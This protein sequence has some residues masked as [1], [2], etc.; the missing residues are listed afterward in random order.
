M[1]DVG[2][3]NVQIEDADV[4]DQVM[5]VGTPMRA[6][7]GA[8]IVVANAP[9]R[10]QPGEIT[11][12]AAEYAFDALSQRRP[13]RFVVA[14]HDPWSGVTNWTAMPCACVVGVPKARIAGRSSSD[15]SFGIMAFSLVYF[16]T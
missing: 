7:G 12:P 4:V 14:V 10:S 3:A 16:F 6:V 1:P 11:T 8:E 15:S 2:V 13:S 9:L 5:S